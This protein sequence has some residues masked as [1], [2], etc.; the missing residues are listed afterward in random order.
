[1]NRTARVLETDH[2][3]ISPTFRFPKS[4]SY[5]ALIAKAEAIIA[6]ATPPRSG[7]L[8]IAQSGGKVDDVL[9]RDQGDGEEGQ[10]ASLKFPYPK[11]LQTR[12]H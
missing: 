11:G 6:A 5:P 3:D 4:A 7:L 2:P 1:M 10:R 12:W 8:K 9:P